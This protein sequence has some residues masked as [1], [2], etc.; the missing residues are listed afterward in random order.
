MFSSKNPRRL[1]NP[2]DKMSVYRERGSGLIP[3][4]PNQHSTF[5]R[6]DLCFFKD[7]FKGHWRRLLYIFVFVFYVKGLRPRE[8]SKDGLTNK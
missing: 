8:S 7:D 4:R 5:K 6:F 2:F 1:V 3:R